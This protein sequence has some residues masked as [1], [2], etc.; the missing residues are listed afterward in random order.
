MKLQEIA[1][2]I[3]YWVAADGKEYRLDESHVTWA[4]KRAGITLPENQDDPTYWTAQGRVYQFMFSR[5]WMRTAIDFAPRYMYVENMVNSRHKEWVLAQ[6]RRYHL[7]AQDTD[8][9]EICDFRGEEPTQEAVEPKDFIMAAGEYHEML[10]KRGYD[11]RETVTADERSDFY[12]KTMPSGVEVNVYVNKSHV[13]DEEFGGWEAAVSARFGGRTSMGVVYPNHISLLEQVV[14][15]VEKAADDPLV[16][17]DIKSGTGVYATLEMLMQNLRRKWM[18]GMDEAAKV[19][20]RLV[21]LAEGPATFVTRLLESPI[22]FDARNFILSP[23]V[24]ILRFVH[25]MFHG[26]QVFV[27][28]KRQGSWPQPIGSVVETPDRNWMILLGRYKKGK[29]LGNRWVWWDEAPPEI[30]ALRFNT[31]EEAGIKLWSLMK[32]KYTGLKEAAPQDARD[33][34]LDQPSFNFHPHGSLVIVMIADQPKPKYSGG[35]NMWPRSLGMLKAQGDQWRIAHGNYRNPAVPD[36]LK[37]RLFNSKEEAAFELW[38]LAK[39]PQPPTDEA[40][41]PAQDMIA[42]Y[43]EESLCPVCQNSDWSNCRCVKCG[44]QWT[45]VYEGDNLVRLDISET[46]IRDFILGNAG[47]LQYYMKAFQPV[48]EWERG[49]EENP[50]YILRHDYEF[51]TLEAALRAARMKCEDF[52]VE[53]EVWD[54]PADSWPHGDAPVALQNLYLV[55]GDGELKEAPPE[56]KE[57]LIAYNEGTYR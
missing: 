51:K 29:V 30:R 3:N 46:D 33:W 48:D 34:I 23:N 49:S 10:L 20:R 19:A 14:A 53:I 8:G 24:P 25:S 26:E 2:A 15:D 40:K 16:A 42:A 12:Q 32:D 36:A 17:K 56:R 44:S 4:A 22:E 9:K 45:E 52:Y 54:V 7:L 35:P 6:S 13:F 39:D 37:A 11:H 43:L 31:K 41:A 27:E 57:Q 55:T 21:M 38:K 18:P 47:T 5:R 1:G 28:K 50:G